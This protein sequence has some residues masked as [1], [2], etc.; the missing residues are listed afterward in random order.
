MKK[1]TKLFG[2][3]NVK[4]FPIK[5]DTEF[6]Y[7]SGEGIDLPEARQISVTYEM[8]E[9]RLGD[10]CHNLDVS[11]RIK[12]ISYEMEYAKLAPSEVE[13]L[14][15]QPFQ[16]K[17]QIFNTS[18]DGGDVHLCIYKVNAEVTPINEKDDCITCLITG[19]GEY[20]KHEFKNISKLI[21][22][23]V[24]AA[25]KDLQATEDITND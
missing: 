12:S 1:V 21:D 24:H 25:A 2:V 5:Q 17:A 19:K 10:D 3:D 20:T 14:K 16:L 11:N 18:N 9:K 15:N 7:K 8:E 22:V 6:A 4:L 13:K 23:E